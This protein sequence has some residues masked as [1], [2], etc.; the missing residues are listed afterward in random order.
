MDP[1]RE[2]GQS[3]ADDALWCDACGADVAPEGATGPGI[4]AK[5]GRS[6]AYDGL[7]CDECFQG[8]VAFE[9]EARSPSA[10]LT[11]QATLEAVPTQGQNESLPARLR[12]LPIGRAFGVAVLWAILIALTWAISPDLTIVATVAFAPIW[13]L[14]STVRRRHEKGLA[15]EK[16][17]REK[18]A[19]T[20]KAW[21]EAILAIVFQ[22]A[23]TLARRR[24]QLVSVDPY[25]NE[26]IARWTEEIAYFCKKVIARRLGPIPAQFDAELPHVI[27]QAALD[28][29]QE[30]AK[31]G[32]PS[33]DEIGSLSGTEFEELCARLLTEAGWYARLTKGSGDQG[34]DIE[35][36][37]LGVTVIVQCKRYA[38]PVGNRA[39][40]EAIAARHYYGTAHAA[41]VANTTF[42]SAAADL[43]RASGVVLLHLEEL[44]D[45]HRRLT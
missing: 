39:V 7:L 21:T 19:A 1:C 38:A 5:C 33:P 6:L 11:D 35:A 41:V 10:R 22:H 4:C 16:T 45:L 20:E 18:A 23:G 17:A 30:L 9:V 24:R 42:T 2:C 8:T 44:P 37:R 12:G 27:N 26:D 36:E 34:G 32:F 15:A 40:Q 31:K 43:A 13:L 3:L 29:E 25:G 14:I 28:H